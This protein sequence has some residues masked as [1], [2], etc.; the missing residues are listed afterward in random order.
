MARGF[1]DLGLHRI[2]ATCDPR[3]LG[4]AR[5]LGKLGMTREGR[6]RHTALIRD[7]WRDSDMFS[8]LEDEWRA[9]TTGMTRRLVER[10][11]PEPGAAA[12]CPANR[13]SSARQ[14]PTAEPAEMM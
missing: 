8:A 3:N 6:H 2:H 13:S 12:L 5:V 10:Y 1:E 9:I 4:S 7:G 14:G 11:D